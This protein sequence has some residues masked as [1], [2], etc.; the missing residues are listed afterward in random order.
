M[1]SKI[2]VAS[3]DG[4]RIAMHFGRTPYFAIFTVEDGEIKDRELR[5]NT[6]TPHVQNGG[7]EKGS[8]DHSHGSKGHSC[9][10]QIVDGLSDCQAVV[11]GGAGRRIVDMLTEAGI[12]MVLTHLSGVDD[13]ISAYLRGELKNSV[14]PCAGH[15]H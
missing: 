3:E 6:F 8:H 9:G 2:A 7:H 5:S 12:K 11:C 15:D 13:T 10:S 4:V 1:A 14:E